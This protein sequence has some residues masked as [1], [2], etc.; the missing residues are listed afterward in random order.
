MY[1]CFKIC[2]PRLVVLE[3]IIVLMQTSLTHSDLLESALDQSVKT[4]I[5]CPD[6]LLYSA[7]LGGSRIFPDDLWGSTR[8]RI[9]LPKGL[10]L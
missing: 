4:P 6:L 5:L 8:L 9:K 3:G 10:L 7:Y 1:F 2:I